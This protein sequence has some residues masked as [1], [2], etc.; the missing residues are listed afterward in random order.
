MIVE[1]ESEFVEQRP[2]MWLVNS[3]TKF[4]SILDSFHLQGRNDGSGGEKLA[5][6][7][8]VIIIS[9]KRWYTD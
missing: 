7:R 8:V 4:L 9:N 3:A 6:G 2:K 1:I 5:K